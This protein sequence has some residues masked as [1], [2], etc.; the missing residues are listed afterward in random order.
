MQEIVQPMA[1]NLKRLR[2]GQNLSI[3]AVAERAGISKSTLSNL[4]RGNGNPSIDT[5][6]LLAR[7]LGV[8]FAALFE[9][10]DDDVDVLRFEDAPLVARSR[11]GRPTATDGHGF[12]LRHL[13]RFTGRGEV[14]AYILDLEANARR[15]AR[16]H[17]TGVVEHVIVVSGRVDV[18]AEGES[19][20]L[21]PG[22]RIRF[23]ADREHHY[24]ALD[25]PAR[26]VAIL[27]YP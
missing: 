4:E 12:G 10:E 11:G 8:P 16:A 18:G 5:L 15:S 1:R 7:V 22:D 27:A 3:S 9:E 26:L 13:V 25:G 17:A 21:G 14:E 20:A 24:E 23:A 6:W 2:E 19:A